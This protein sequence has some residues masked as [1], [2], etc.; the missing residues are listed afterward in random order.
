VQSDVR[1]LTYDEIASAFTINR[2]SA[3]QLVARKR[4]ARRKGNDGK[5]RI[6]VPNDALETACVDPD[7]L[8]DTIDNT[9][10]DP[11]RDP[12]Q[13]AGHDV[14][15]VAVLSRQIERLEVD[16]IAAKEEL[17]LVKTERDAER[18]VAAQVNVLKAVLEVEQR[19]AGELREE[20]DKWHAAA[21]APR[22][23]FGWGWFRRAAR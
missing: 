23:L 7:P 8:H 22:G 15:V 4:W 2:E 11:P 9:S 20:R 13:N 5:A 6:E 21:M 10:A 12:L 19:R 1:L 18:A 16:L 3:R 14:C 17:A